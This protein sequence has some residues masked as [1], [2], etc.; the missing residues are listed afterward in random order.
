MAIARS[1]KNIKKNLP[2]KKLPPKH[3]AVARPPPPNNTN[4]KK[5]TREKQRSPLYD[6]NAH[7]ADAPGAYAVF[8]E[9]GERQQRQLHT[10]SKVR[11]SK[12]KKKWSV[13]KK[14]VNAP[15][16]DDG[17]LIVKEYSSEPPVERDSTVVALANF[18]IDE[19][20]EGGD[21]ANRYKTKILVG[22][23]AGVFVVVAVATGITVALSANSRTSSSS[24]TSST[25]G[26]VSVTLFGQVYESAT[27][28][29]VNLSNQ[30]G[31]STE[32][33]LVDGTIPTEIGF[34][35]RLTHLDLSFNNDNLKGQI[36]SEVGTLTGLLQLSLENNSL[37]GLI[38]SEIGLLTQLTSLSLRYNSLSGTL[39]SEIGQLKSLEELYLESNMLSGSIPSAAFTRLSSL[40]TLSLFRNGLSG[41]LPS[42]LCPH[43][44]P[45]IDCTEIWC[46]CCMGSDHIYTR[47]KSSA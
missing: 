42:A 4:S 32:P 17:I 9:A 38:C 26:S 23:V 5:K 41:S 21:G 2:S 31:G 10:S 27:T 24:S 16:T 37:D 34:L 6:D 13:T 35:T 30:E 45:R 12:R 1:S 43:V 7:D 11:S 25:K 15:P 33:R 28:T 8:G 29:V 3:S 47:C 22:F 46:T 39:P 18:N 36:P 40:T 19:R 44:N 14:G 20:G